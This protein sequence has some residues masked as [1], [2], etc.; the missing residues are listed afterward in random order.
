[1]CMEYLK[2][3]IKVQ[4]FVMAIRQLDN[5]VTATTVCTWQLYQCKDYGIL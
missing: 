3:S 4:S 1:M 5:I 2:I